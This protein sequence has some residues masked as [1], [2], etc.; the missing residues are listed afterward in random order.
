MDD[1]YFK[2][3]MGVVVLF[4]LLV[5]T[6]F[7]LKPLIVPIILAFLLAFIFN[8]IYVRIN[9]KVKSKNLSATIVSLILSLIIFIPVWFLTPIF[10][11]QSLRFYQ[12][13]QNLDYRQ[14]FNSLSPALS[15]TSISSE[16]A[17]IMSSFTTKTANSVLDAF[18]KIILNFPILLL[19][20]LVMSFTFFFVLRDKEELVE[21]IKS[22]LPFSKE[23]E[24]K[25]FEY[26]RG[27]TSAI[28]YGQ[29]IIGL[30]QGIVAGLGFLLF[31]AP[32]PFLLTLLAIVLG[33]LP[34]VGTTWVWVP[35]AIYMFATVGAL[36]AIGIML[37]GILS[38]V[39]DN[40]VR[41]VLVA[42]RAKIH[43]ALLL[44]GM[45]GGL[46][47]MGILGVV[48]GPLIIAYLIILLEVYRNKKV[49]GILIDPGQS[50]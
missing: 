18:T 35:V 10:I 45:I 36:P 49:S 31:D 25:I 33:V 12:T 19:Q 21:Y 15:S 5:L 14:L 37:F 27:I 38:N 34:I 40:V 23:V 46:F 20:F 29:V 13:A 17:S 6:F 9:N 8:P 22:V 39:L 4:F 11:E 1:E 24:K 43:S 30:L 28:I 42:K 3:V 41:P 50:K 2:R 44:V 48:V 16:I 47:L 32:S 7:L 26:S